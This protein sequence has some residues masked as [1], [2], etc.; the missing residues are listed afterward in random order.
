MIGKKSKNVLATAE[1]KA[2]LRYFYIKELLTLEVM[3]F[4]G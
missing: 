3:I 1:A 2:A 4:V